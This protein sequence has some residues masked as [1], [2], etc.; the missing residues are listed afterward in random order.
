MGNEVSTKGNVAWNSVGM[1]AIEL[2]KTKTK[3]L[4]KRNKVLVEV[5]AKC[6]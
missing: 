2:E 6:M 1:Y 3:V 5:Y 4:L